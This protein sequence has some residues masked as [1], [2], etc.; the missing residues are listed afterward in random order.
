MAEIITS[1]NPGHYPTGQ[2]VTVTFP[3]GT[4]KAIVTTGDRPPVLTEILA[5]DTGPI[6]PGTTPQ[7][8]PFLAVTQ[9]GKGN[10][11]YDGGFPKFYNMRMCTDFE[12]DGN[13]T[14]IQMVFPAQR[15]STRDQLTPSEQYL[16]NELNFIA[17]V[18]KVGLGNRKIL[19]VNNT[20]RGDI[21]NIYGSYY[22]PD[23]THSASPGVNVYT[24]YGFRDTFD[25]VC[26]VGNWIPTY[27][28]CT[29]AGGNINLSTEY[30]DQ[31]A[32]VV[33]VTSW[34]VA[35]ATDTRMTEAF[36]SNLA[37]YR[38]FGN[39]VAVIADHCGGNYTSLQDAIANVSE[40]GAGGTQ[41]AKYYSAYFSG[42]VDRSPVSVGEIRR[43]IGGD[44]P[45]FAGMSDSELIHAG[46]SESLVF[47]ED[48]SAYEVPIR[49]YT[50]NFNA[51]G[52][53][54]INVLVQLNDGTII[55][56]NL[57]YVIISP[58]D[59]NMVDYF[60]RG[61]GADGMTTYKQAI[62]YSILVNNISDELYGKIFVD[63]MLVGWFTTSTTG[64]KRVT[65]YSPL[66]GPSVPMIVKNGQRLKFIIQDPFEYEVNALI[67]IPDSL[68]YWNACFSQATFLSKLKTHPYFSGVSNTNV[69]SDVTTFSDKVYSVSRSLGN[70]IYGQWWKVIGKGRPAFDTVQTYDP[71][72]LKIYNNDTAWNTAKPTI[73][74]VGDAVIVA[75]TNTVYYWDDA[76][77]SWI[78]HS[79]KA[80]ALFGTGRKAVNLV[81]NS[82]WIVNTTNTTKVT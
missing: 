80:D 47:P 28:D 31:F 30:L 60:N 67:N 50:V 51:A 14:I 58:S 23:P 45:L 3:A 59:I 53:Y 26:T 39:G 1:K 5:Y 18:K 36:A 41:L 44:H 35:T 24:A 40:F 27:Y 66:A 32:A 75:D 43:Q 12:V 4:R 6:P 22:N 72:R 48:T 2:T 29:D 42:N 57:R 61:P 62:D 65:S 73:G 71:I 33:V 64:S 34:G 11:V 20:Y 78:Q 19:F 56:R 37:Q 49:P 9:D 74:K 8:R 38:R 16:V 13:G 17:S 15:P 79:Y 54:R 81:D 69:V 52:T 25:A 7:Q 82:N 55:T 46:E 76:S 77:I 68:P 21:Y 63:N 10:V 70:Y